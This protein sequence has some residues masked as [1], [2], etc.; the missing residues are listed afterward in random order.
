MGVLEL[1]RGRVMIVAHAMQ[2]NTEP[3]AQGSPLAPAPTVVL[4]QQANTELGVLEPPL[5]HALCVVL[6]H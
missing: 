2:I 3:G 6:V 4:V 1:R 5:A